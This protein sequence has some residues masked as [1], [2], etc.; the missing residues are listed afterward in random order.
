[1]IRMPI[2]VA[3]K[4]GQ[5]FTA[6]D[7]LA[8]KQVKCP[9]CGGR[10]TIP[11]E[12]AEKADTP[13][14]SA[15]V[16]KGAKGGADRL[17]PG[18]S[19]QRG[20]AGVDQLLE[21]AGLFSAAK[22][23]PNCRAAMDPNAILC[24]EC[25]YNL[26]IGKVMQTMAVTD[27]SAEGTASRTAGDWKTRAQ[28]ALEED[29]ASK[30]KEESVGLPW[31]VYLII[32]FGLILFTG[33]MM[34]VSPVTVMRVAGITLIT[35]GAFATMAGGL[36]LIVEAFRVSIIQGL[37]CLLVPAYILVFAV[38]YWDDATTPAI[39]WFGGA[40]IQLAGWGMYYVSPYMDF[41]G[42]NESAYI[43]M[44]LAQS[45]MHLAV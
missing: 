22:R 36:W 37:L 32:L 30:K 11:R 39:I 35:I 4:C 13:P 26:K 38:M 44:N 33:G 16:G 15:A 20:P 3:C 28:R 41:G 24:V 8:G 18:R 7:E 40:G 19:A 43:L 29:E 6:K 42:A 9:K 27:E 45:L 1:M 5:R 17:P 21:E 12:N 25:G 2:K 34:M 14:R 23:C 31:Y 10:L